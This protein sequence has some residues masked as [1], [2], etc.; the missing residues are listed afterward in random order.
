MERF[1]RVGNV[2]AAKEANVAVFTG[3]PDEPFA[4]PAEVAM[5]A[6]VAIGVGGVGAVAVDHLQLFDGENSA[7][8][9]NV[10]P[11]WKTDEVGFVIAEDV[12]EQGV[13]FCVAEHPLVRFVAENE[14]P[15]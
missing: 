3:L 8:S 2:V 9:E 15:T 1:F 11:K 6:N 10:C 4:R 7:A 5:E 13:E 12:V 14:R